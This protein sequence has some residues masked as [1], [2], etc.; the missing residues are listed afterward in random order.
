MTVTAVSTSCFSRGAILV[1]PF[2]THHNDITWVRLN[3]YAAGMRRL[4]SCALLLLPS[5]QF[6][7]VLMSGQLGKFTGTVF[8]PNQTT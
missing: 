5:M 7:P 3:P 8:F 1:Q 4:R 2:C 6:M